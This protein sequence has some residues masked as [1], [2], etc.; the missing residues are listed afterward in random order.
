VAEY[1]E[2]GSFD[3]LA[4]AAATVDQVTPSERT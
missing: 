1:G 2:S 3:V 4:R